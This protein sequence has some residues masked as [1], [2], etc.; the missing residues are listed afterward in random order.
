MKRE[1]APAKAGV[2]PEEKILGPG[3]RRG[4]VHW[5]SVR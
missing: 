3:L 1:S 2:Q 4:T 5:N